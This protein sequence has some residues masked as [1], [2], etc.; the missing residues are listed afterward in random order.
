M[1]KETIKIGLPE[2]HY[3]DYWKHFIELIVIQRDD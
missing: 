1:E 3:H 2:E